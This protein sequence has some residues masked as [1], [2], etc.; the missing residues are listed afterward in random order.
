MN[1]EFKI[2]I[3]GTLTGYAGNGGTVVIPDGVTTIGHYAFYDCPSL[4]E[5][6]VPDGVTSIGNY[7]FEGC[8]RL[9]KVIIPDSVTY[10]GVSAF[11]GCPCDPNKPT[12]KPQSISTKEQ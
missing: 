12:E 11:D 6:V 9:T 4:T 3:N 7:A 8:T 5:V 1:N 2:E 10:I